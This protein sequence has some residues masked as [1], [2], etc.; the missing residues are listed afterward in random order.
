MALEGQQDRLIG[1]VH[2]VAAVTRAVRA[3]DRDDA[4]WA[5][6]VRRGMALTD[7]VVLVV[8]V[9]ATQFL[10]FGSLTTTVRLIPDDQ[11]RVLGYLVVSLLLVAGWMGS[12]ALSDSRSTRMLGSGLE[13]YRAVAV[14]TFRLFGAVA[15]IA[16]LGRINLARGY[17]AIVF[18]A[19]FV[20]L[21]VSRWVWR[22]W[23]VRQRRRGRCSRRVIL[24]GSALSVAQTARELRRLPDA[25]YAV[26]GS[27]VPH[28]EALDD[29]SD[30]DAGAL[31]LAEAIE[32][33]VT[34]V[35]ADTVIVAGSDDLPP[36]AVKRLSWKLESGRRHL[37][38]S[39]GIADVAGPRI[40]LRPVAGL[41]LIHVETPRLSTGQLVLKR[42]LDVV[43]GVLGIILIS[44]LLA[45]AAVMVK[46]TSPG[47]VIFRQRRV[48]LGG[49]EFV[50]FK[51]RSMHAGA[52]G[53]LPSLLDENRQAGN[54][55]LFKMRHDPRITPVGRWMRR[56]SIDELPQLFNVVRGDMSF[57]GPRPPL[58]RE[59][60]KYAQHVH[61]RFL[62]KPGITG[63]WQVSGRST[64]SWED[65]VRLDLS[66]VENY[67]AVGDL[68]ILAKTVRA[69]L[70]PGETAW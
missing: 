42:A 39:A 57:V 62:M 67:S 15:I 33:A 9:V 46:A 17:L 66:Y 50:M 35:Q 2:G 43:G 20:L 69:V 59:V 55:V 54:E 38:L 26:V 47:P 14:A 25:G 61:R 53:A 48:G 12:L 58:R 3:L 31:V 18:P 60:E 29:A 28:P 16:L 23:L 36:S 11:T 49:R 52:E 64:L 65:T 5:W 21:L 6:Q 70:F 37:V 27:Y 30:P 40:H 56:F 22:Q 10:W 41:P 8:T 51:F 7:L 24:V 63:L 68:V 34:G 44:P 4:G 19:G 13:E 1:G 45:V 32:R